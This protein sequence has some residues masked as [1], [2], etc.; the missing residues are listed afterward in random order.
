MTRLQELYWDSTTPQARIID[1]SVMDQSIIQYGECI[2]SVG[3]CI[4]TIP[5]ISQTARMC[6]VCHFLLYIDRLGLFHSVSY[7]KAGSMPLFNIYILH[8]E[9]SQT[10]KMCDHFLLTVW[11][12]ESWSVHLSH[13]TLED[14]KITKWTQYLT[15]FVIPSAY[16]VKKLIK[17]VS[18][19]HVPWQP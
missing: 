10:S 8:C 6:I 13:T 12:W 17:S 15:V 7:L 3:G 2:M 5:L 9:V 4:C 11:V 16:L 14:Y 19:S 18:L 1:L